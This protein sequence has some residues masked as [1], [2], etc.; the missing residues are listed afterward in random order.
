MGV[1]FVH[2][3]RVRYAECDMQG[4]VFNA[5]YLAYFDASMTELWRAAFGGYQAMLDRGV[6]M[7]V[8][9]TRLRFHQPARFDDQLTLEVAISRLGNT[10]IHSL[11]RIRRDDVELVDG[12]LRHVL[13]DRATLSKT[14]L[15][16][17]AR[18]GLRPWTV[19]APAPDARTA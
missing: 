7:V 19:D 6:D 1:P 5:H 12:T 14:E 13:V 8:A 11:H 18:S 4:V 15:P 16:E 3:L 9:E 10:S 2:S 17:W